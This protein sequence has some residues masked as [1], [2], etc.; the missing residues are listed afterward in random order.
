MGTGITQVFLQGGFKVILLDID[1]GI[2]K[3]AVK[4]IGDIYSLLIEKEKISPENKDIYLSNLDTATSLE[5]LKDMPLVIETVKEDLKI[6]KELLGKIEKIVP[7]H[8]IITSN[9]S[10]FSINKLASGLKKPGR[11]I[12]LHFFNPAPLL[13]LVEVV[14]G[15]KTLKKV[16][17]EIRRISCNL[18]ETD[19]KLIALTLDH[20]DQAILLSDDYSVQNIAS[21]L[22]LKFSSVKERGIREAIEW[23]FQCIGCKKI[24]DATHKTCTEC[25]S[26]LRRIRVDPKNE[27]NSLK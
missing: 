14:A 17:D 12:G 20:K 7:E 11:F 26:K 25:G 4:R 5:I 8:T 23:K 9:T 15:E 22:N 21:L 16:K 6:K 2:L 27:D 13:P 3:K 18:S 1:P 10:S 19:T 24:Y